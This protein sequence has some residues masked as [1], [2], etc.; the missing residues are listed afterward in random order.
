MKDPAPLRVVYLEELQDKDK[1]LPMD[2]GAEHELIQLA[3]QDPQAFSLLYDRYVDR[4]YAYALR[5]TGDQD[6][7]KD[8]TSV[9]FEKALRGL[10]RYR[11]RGVSFGAWLYRIARHE[12]LAHYRK[13]RRLVTLP[14]HLIS[15][16]NVEEMIQSRD[17][18]DGLHAALARIPARDQELLALRFFEDLSSPEVAE[19]LGCSTNNVYVRLHR[20]LKRLRKELESNEARSESDV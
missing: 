7:A 5:R 11:W 19:V 14:L 2:D 12:M 9:T 13:Q 20:A 1:P 4:I 6:L 15:A 18:V 16:M 10:Q 8:M 3:K 17:Q